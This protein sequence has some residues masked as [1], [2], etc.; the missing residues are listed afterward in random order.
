VTEPKH[1]W[2]WKSVIKRF[3]IIVPL[4][5][6]FFG[7]VSGFLNGNYVASFGISAI[8]GCTL[9]L[10]FASDYRWIQPRLNHL[11]RDK[12]LAL[13]ILFAT[14]ETVLG[15]MLAFWISGLVF[16]FS[17]MEPSVW[18][19]ILIG[20]GVFLVF[21]SLRYATQF[22]RD[23]KTKDLIEERLK[24]LAAQAELKALKAQ[25]NPHFLFNTL[26]TIAALTHTNPQKA[27]E[28]IEKLAEMFRYALMS[29]ERGK[30]SLREEL[31][32]TNR[33][34]EIEKVR[35]DESLRIRQE[36]ERDVDDVL[37]PPLVLQPLVENAIRHGRGQDGSV[38]LMIRMTTQEDE[39]AISIADRGPGMQIDFR[40]VKGSGVGLRN[41]DERLRKTYGESYGL[42]IGSNE[43]HG[44]IIAFRIPLE[45]EMHDA[46]KLLDE[47]DRS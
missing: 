30:V 2:D 16:G 41:V 11:P 7:L 15:F 28:T 20:F 22:Y 36:I 42:E 8:I 46:V 40:S 19:S 44:A 45:Q 12:R 1:G 31:S 43:P 24:T 32:F 21:R 13:E 33:Y 34:L 17:I 35:F 39:L 25:I 29:S 6:I 9:F 38:D 27:E 47:R 4:T 5:T 18:V 10:I 23:L 37:V 26:N 3:L 14:I